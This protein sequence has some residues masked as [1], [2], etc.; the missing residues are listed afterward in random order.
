MA[1][2][3][4]EGANTVDPGAGTDTDKGAAQVTLAGDNKGAPENG[5][6]DAPKTN[7]DAFADLD[8]ETR[9][10]LSKR[11]I[12]DPKVAMR[13]AYDQAKL[14]GNAIRVPGKDATD[15]ERNEFLNK[16]GR[17]ADPDGYEIAPPKD[18]P[19]ELPYDGE[20]A[21]EFKKLAHDLGLTATQAQKLHDWAATNAVQ[22]FTSFSAKQQAQT[23]ETAKAETEK[24]VKRW[25]P[26]T[27]A[28]AKANIELADRALQVGG[29][30][31]VDELKR[32]KMI[33]PNKEILSEPLAVLFA[34]IGAALFQEDS[35][36]RGNPDVIG[37][38]FA[39]GE[40][41]NLTTAMAVQ[42]KD[43]EHALSL[44]RAAGKK[45]SDFGL[46]G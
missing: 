41:F 12:S 11:G 10:W 36:I 23:V 38:P 16:L 37:N 17:P 31:V 30:D 7:G 13:L 9:E 34:N 42:K 5:S 33:G 28:T 29:Q 4:T 15:E 25:G 14:L 43:P 35:T 2:E 19:P 24:L 46:R 45:P 26:L 1:T 22:D 6:A 39:D 27:S 40:H 8:G 32:L 20:R 21:T 44:I 3:G 18:L